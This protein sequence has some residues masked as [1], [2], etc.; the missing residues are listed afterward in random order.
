MTRTLTRPAPPAA[1]APA[2][3]KVLGLLAAVGVGTLIAVQSRINGELGQRMHDGTGAAVVSFGSGLLV[4]FVLVAA[5]PSG[6]RGLRA[7]RVALRSG[8]LRW[9]QTLGGLC[10]ALLV[11]SQGYAAASLGVAVFTVAV[12]A[13]QAGSSLL[14]DR[15]GLGPAGPQP[16]TATRVVGAVLAVAAVVLAVSDRFGSPAALALAVLPA[17][18]GLGISWQQA[19]N[20]R[21]KEAA[22]AAVPAAL[23]NFLTG[24]AVLLVAGVVHV[25]FAGWPAALP[26]EPVLYLGGVIGVLFIAV[27]A[28]LVRVT[29]VLLLGLGSVAGQLLGAL[30]LDV[31]FPAAGTNLSAVTVGGTLLTLV[32]VGIAALPARVGVRSPG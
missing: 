2:R 1:P 21:V 25:A 31:L 29:G 24:T 13:G 6:R 8:E 32:A 12:V 27:A 28:A 26:A 10:G 16:L 7:V 30:V 3:T 9:W 17:L 15:A 11:F 20:G 18:A 19:V 5:L 14:V 22:G 23:V 4:L